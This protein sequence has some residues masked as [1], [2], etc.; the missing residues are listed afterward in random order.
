MLD[1]RRGGP[2]LAHALCDGAHEDFRQV[3]ALALPGILN[4][5]APDRSNDAS[6][7]LAVIK[8]TVQVA[9]G[10]FT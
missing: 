1:G 4:E 2:G 3:G 5:L 6:C 10:R 8:L 7:R 9:L